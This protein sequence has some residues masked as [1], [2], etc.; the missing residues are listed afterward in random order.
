MPEHPG[1]ARA[2]LDPLTRLILDTAVGVLGFHAATAILHDGDD[3]AT[4]ASTDHNLDALNDA[5]YT[6]GARPLPGHP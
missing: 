5:Q 1:A 2:W 6:A 3:L 4:M